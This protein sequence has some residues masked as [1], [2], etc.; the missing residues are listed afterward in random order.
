MSNQ[1][2]QSNKQYPQSNQQQ[3]PQQYPLQYPQYQQAQI[4]QSNDEQ[5]Q[6]QQ[7]YKPQQHHDS[8]QQVP[9]YQQS[10][11]QNNVAFNIEEQQK[12]PLDDFE[13]ADSL[14]C[15]VGFDQ[16]KNFIVKVYSLLTIQLFVTFLMVTIAC[17]SQQFRDLLINPNNYEATPFYWTMFSISFVTELAIFCFKKL[18]RKVPNNYIAL[19]IF[20]ISFS[21]VVA[22]SCA[23]CKDV[24]V[25]G[26]TLI[27]IAALMTFVV[28]A[29]L[30]VYAYKT[31]N[32]FTLAGG[33]LF[34]FS[35]ILFI[36]FIFAYCFFDLILWLILCSFSVI[37]Y[38]F[39]LIY[40][41]QLIIGGKTHKLTIDDYVIG[42]MFIYI[43][44]II[45]FLRI[46]QILM[47]LFGKK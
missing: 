1:Q 34:I 5:S 16:R 14:L 41:T 46:L 44:V 36:L 25:N 11:P 19:T 37:L 39:Y 30:T 7:Y 2:V 20:T 40:D 3:Y 9:H 33:S 21:F 13:H 43:D 10:I 22:G 17:F 23:L 45:M 15:N 31:K 32:D 4:Q 47:I 18:A 29:S 6:Q 42:T 12:N 28:T 8:Y 24:F 38:G 26:G 27:L 35:S